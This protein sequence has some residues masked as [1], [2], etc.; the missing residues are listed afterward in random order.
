MT[1]SK[2][3]SSMCLNIIYMLVVT[4][5]IPLPSPH[6]I[7]NN[8]YMCNNHLKFHMSKSRHTI[9]TYDSQ[10]S[11]FSLLHVPSSSCLKQKSYS[12]PLLFFVSISITDPSANPID[13]T[14]KRYPISSH[15]LSP[16]LTPWTKASFHLV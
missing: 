9:N 16:P 1:R 8:M 14:F 6:G 7:C 15:F 12:Y 4:K 2:S 5:F 3:A 13:C 11:P 10:T